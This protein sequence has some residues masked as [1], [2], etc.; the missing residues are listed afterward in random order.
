MLENRTAPCN[1][2]NILD[3]GGASN[4]QGDH[5]AKKLLAEIPAYCIVIPKGNKHGS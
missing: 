4:R 1:W 5:A 2:E 3:P